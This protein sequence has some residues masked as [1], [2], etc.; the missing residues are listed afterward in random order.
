MGDCDYPSPRNSKCLVLRVTAFV[1]FWR[2][3]RAA[4][5][6]K[7]ICDLECLDAHTNVFKW[8]SFLRYHTHH[9]FLQRIFH[10]H[11]PKKHTSAISTWAKEKRGGKHGIKK[12]SS[13]SVQCDNLSV[14]LELFVAPPENPHTSFLNCDSS[15]LSRVF[16]CEEASWS[17]FFFFFYV[18]RPTVFTT[19]N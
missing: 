12:T 4:A 3:Q 7:D 6:K 18:L 19:V 17:A 8:W 14:K 11:T 16:S 13:T 2:M 9:I 15:H 10:T 5:Q 1:I